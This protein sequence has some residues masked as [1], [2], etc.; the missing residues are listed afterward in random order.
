M[1]RTRLI[2][3]PALATESAPY[4]ILDAGG[5]VLQRGRLALDSGEAPPPMRTVAIAPGG[6]VAVRWLDLPVGGTA[7]IRAA[8]L[9]TLR[10][11]LAATPDRVTV[12]L[13]RAVPVGEPRMAVV[14]SRALVEAWGDYLDA[15]GIKADVILPDMLTLEVPEAEN[16]L[17]AVTFGSGLALRGHR[18]AATIQPDLLDLIAGAREVRPVTEEAEVERLMIAAALSPE[19]NLLDAVGREKTNDR[20]GWRLAAGLA[21]AVLVSPL[22]LAATQAARDTGAAR[23]AEAQTVEL[24]A[25]VSPEAAGAPDPV[26]AFR[27]RA[28]TAPPPG[29]ITSAAAV[30]FAAVEQVDGAELDIFV[31]DPEGG[32]RATVS[33]PAYQDLDALK[34][35]VAAAGLRLNDTS[36]LDDAG[37]VVSDVTIGAAT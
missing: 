7:Q 31:S 34:S 33:Y 4:L 24:I 5:S 3:I 37:R 36:T 20:R 8:A 14:A 22:I 9:W 25:Q 17:S 6:D 26:A 29:G 21:A 30:L 1:S 23:Q 2:L 27:Q 16:G 35:A 10:D 18:F 15:L 32:V 11:D 13:G 12:S 28:A 19:I